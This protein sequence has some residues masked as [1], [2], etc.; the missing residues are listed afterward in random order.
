[1]HF[2]ASFEYSVFL[3][4]VL[5]E[6]EKNGVTKENIQ[7]FPLDKRL[8]HGKLFDTI[9]QSDGISLFDLAA[10]LAMIFM[11]LGC[12][13]GYIL[14]LGPVIWALIGLVFG[15]LLGFAIKYIRYKKKYA[16]KIKQ[17]KEQAS[18][19][20]LIIKVD[21]DSTNTKTIE[22]ILWNHFALGLCKVND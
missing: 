18:E 20:I 1:M 22:N 21:K 15:A 17:K 4:L 16:Y 13:Y 19:V 11:L 12:I 7:A 9:H 6:L 3:E 14:P 5:T 2:I 8:E 10:I